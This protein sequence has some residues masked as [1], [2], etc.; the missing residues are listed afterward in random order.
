M[1][2]VLLIVT[3][4]FIISNSQAQNL[5]GLLNKAKDAVSGKP[6]GLGNDEI[7]AGLKEALTVGTEKGTSMLSKEN[8]FFGND[9]LKIVLPPDAQKIEKTLRSV[10]KNH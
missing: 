6:I 5:K 1:K 3:S 10:G 7:I 8:G 9:L 2:Y 4:L